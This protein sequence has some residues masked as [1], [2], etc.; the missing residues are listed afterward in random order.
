M[1]VIFGIFIARVGGSRL[2]I[3]PIVALILSPGEPNQERN[4]KPLG[5]RP[6]SDDD[7]CDLYS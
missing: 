6:T 4:L 7:S 5:E 3:V 2:Y 1:E